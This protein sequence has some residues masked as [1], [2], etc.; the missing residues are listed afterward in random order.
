[1]DTFSYLFGD[2]FGMH[3]LL[4]STKLKKIA[5]NKRAYQYLGKTG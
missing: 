3:D 1:M 4:S 2:G 5:D